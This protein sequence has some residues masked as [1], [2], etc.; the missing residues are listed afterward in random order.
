MRDVRAETVGSLLRPE[1]LRAARHRFTAGEIGEAEM[2]QA[3]DE[4]V[5]GAI[6]LQE[7]VGL[8][9]ITDGEMR[10]RSWV[11][12]GDALSGF[13]LIPGGAGWKWHGTDRAERFD[14]MPYP[15]ITEPIAVKRDLAREEAAFLKGHTRTRTKY[16]IPA[17]SYSRTFWHP[18]HSRDAYPTV[19]EFLVAIRDYTRGLVRDLTSLGYDY[20][21]LDAPNYGFVCDADFRAAMAAQG[22]DLAANLA[23][24]ID[25]DSSTFDGIIG[26]TRA[27]HI[28]RGNAAGNWAASGGYDAIAAD[29]FPR[30]RLDRLLLEYD[31]P[32]SGDFGA[33]RH[34]RPDTAVV[35]GLLTTK[36]G[37]LEDAAA[38]E[39][40]IREASALVPLERLALSPQCGFASV[41]SGNPVNQQQQEAKLRLVGELARRVWS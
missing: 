40:R 26:V 7:A 37:D 12:T 30:L 1:A 3:E 23:F 41:A 22:R 18:D 32:R 31:T 28:C 38:V 14:T 25:L 4:A 16:C 21:Q 2:R 20:I 27:L 11:S 35:L 34:V 39:A 24:D 10:R 5:L 6:K 19:D 13:T 8:D 29:F 33:L 15:F 36:A 17:P 9:V